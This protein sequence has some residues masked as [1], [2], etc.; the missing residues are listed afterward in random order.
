MKATNDFKNTLLKR[1][2]VTFLMEHT[3]N[4]GYAA[5]SKEVAEKFKVEENVIV[6]KELRGHFGTNEFLARAFIYDSVAA[7]E[8]TEPKARVKAKKDGSA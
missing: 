1:R 3:S 5:V 7:K 4:P 8:F 2:E 6:V